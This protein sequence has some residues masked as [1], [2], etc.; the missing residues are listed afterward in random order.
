MSTDEQ[1]EKRRAYNRRWM[2]KR[3]AA[4]RAER[5]EEVSLFLPLGL[6]RELRA[7]KPKGVAFNLWLVK[8]LRDRGKVAASAPCESASEASSDSFSVSPLKGAARNAPCPCGC[9]RKA[10]NCASGI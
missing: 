10:K 1:R 9:G 3:R 6:A 7:A 4:V 2:A 8:V 5:G